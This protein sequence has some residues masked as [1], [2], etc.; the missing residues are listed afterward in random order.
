MRQAGALL[1]SNGQ[2]IVHFASGRRHAFYHVMR[3]GISG[4]GTTRGGSARPR[5][6]K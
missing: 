5:A 1:E 2:L 4:V 6:P 3:V